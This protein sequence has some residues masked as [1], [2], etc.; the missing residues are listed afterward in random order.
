MEMNYYIYIIYMVWVL[1]DFLM[2]RLVNNLATDLTIEKSYDMSMMRH[3]NPTDREVVFFGGSGV[4]KTVIVVNL[5]G[6][7]KDL[8][9]IADS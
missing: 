3:R 6:F 8:K 5:R 4:N 2:R 1:V 7:L 9:P